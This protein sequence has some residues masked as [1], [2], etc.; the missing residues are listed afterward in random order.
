M[1]MIVKSI[2]CV[3]VSPHDEYI[4]QRKMTQL[5]LGHAFEGANDD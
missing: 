4:V 1:T 5:E 3:N 2:G